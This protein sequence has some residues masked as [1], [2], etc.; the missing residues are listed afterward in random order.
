MI[1]KLNPII[2]KIFFVL[3][4]GLFSCKTQITT[5][6]YKNLPLI[7]NLADSMLI[8]GKEAEIIYNPNNE[9]AQYKKI[10]NLYLKLKYYS[11]NDITEFRYKMKDSTNGGFKI[12]TRNVKIPQDVFLVSI[13]IEPFEY[14]RSTENVLTPTFKL[15]NF[16]DFGIPA[17]LENINKFDT[18]LFQEDSKLFN[19]NF[20]RFIAYWDNNKNGIS[21][22][23]IDSLFAVNNQLLNSEHSNY[24][25]NNLSVLI[26]GNFLAQNYERT[27]LLLTDFLSKISKPKVSEFFIIA[28]LSKI[29]DLII[30]KNILIKTSL[31]KEIVNKIFNIFLNFNPSTILTT[32]LNYDKYLQLSLIDKVSLNN[33]ANY[34]NNYYFTFLN[35][36]LDNGI[37]LNASF[38][39]TILLLSEIDT[40][41]N[42]METSRKLLKLG[43]NFFK[44]KIEWPKNDSIANLGTFSKNVLLQMM[45]KSLYLS[46]KNENIN[47][48]LTYLKDFIYN[49]EKSDDM[50]F[51]PIQ[52]IIT[53][54]IRLKNCDSAYTY[55]NLLYDCQSERFDEFR[56]KVDSLAIGENRIDLFNKYKSIF[57]ISLKDFS[58]VPELKIQ[59]NNGL[60]DLN[61]KTKKYFIFL[62]DDN[63]PSCN[64]GM[65][66]FI[67]KFP[68]S[69]KKNVDVVLISKLH[70]QDLVEL[71]GKNNF[72]S[73]DV[74]MVMNKLNIYQ[75]P[76]F[77]IINKGKLIKKDTHISTSLDAYYKYIDL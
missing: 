64:F 11:N 41:F 57:K 10:E 40:L 33:F 12:F 52:T 47:E 71:Y 70:E 17:L 60:L 68:D 46:L 44:N 23:Q 16:S 36:P 22:S 21:K 48:A 20:Q 18:E 13:T 73:P 27:I 28:N 39:H 31:K 56:K 61:S 54:Y 65:Y 4:L 25:L 66:N 67:T 49:V 6:D 72:I 74:D 75:K 63:C 37:K 77:V 30:N 2:I 32:N 5:L 45:S 42:N 29:T 53:E 7:F 14:F 19:Y 34:A 1:N 3:L 50:V 26:L 51:Y 59:T 62:I 35:N 76:G 69:L 9:K 8:Q 15:N 38:G 55:L 24:Y 43:F 58:N